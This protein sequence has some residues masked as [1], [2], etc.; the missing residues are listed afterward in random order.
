M[1]LLF[2][3]VLNMSFTA[4]IVILCVMAAR[5]ALKKAPKIYSYALWSVVLFRLLC[6]VSLASDFSVLELTGPEVS[7]SEAVSYVTYAPVENVLVESSAAIPRLQ[8]ESI[9]V[10]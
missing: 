9:P 3:Q 6:P 2:G 8:T 1:Q 10:K 4:G 7:Q 5:L